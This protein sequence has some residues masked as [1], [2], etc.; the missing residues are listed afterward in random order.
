[1][2]FTK[3]ISFF[4]LTM[5]SLSLLPKN[6]KPPHFLQIFIPFFSHPNKSQD[7]ECYVQSINLLS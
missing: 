2:S 3:H 4:P 5:Y 7:F 1:M 6:K